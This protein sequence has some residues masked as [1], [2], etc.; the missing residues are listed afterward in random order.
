VAK[1]TGEGSRKGAVRDRVQTLNPLT[2]RYVKIDTETGRII[3]HKRT[4]GPYK[5][6]RE[7]TPP[8][9]KKK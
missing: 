6:V 7:V 8:P 2:R 3:D 9:K 4:A 1:N 5:G